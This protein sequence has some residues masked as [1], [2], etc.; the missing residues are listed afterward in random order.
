VEAKP[1]R[2]LLSDVKT[3]A[4]TKGKNTAGRRSNGVPQLL[5][6]RG[7][8]DEAPNTVLCQNVGSDGIDAIWE[9]KADLPGKQNT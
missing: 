3:I 7:D 2:V 9:C 6:K 1:E 8:C 4:L 5:C